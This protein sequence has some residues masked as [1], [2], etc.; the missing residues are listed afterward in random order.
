MEKY[1]KNR[2]MYLD[3]LRF[4]CILIVFIHHV[5]MDV[6]VIHNM[7]DLNDFYIMLFDRKNFNIGMCAIVLY[8]L[9]SGAAMMMVSKRYISNDKFDIVSFYKDRLIR[10]LI[11]FYIVYVMYFIVRFLTVKIFPSAVSGS[12]FSSHPRIYAIFYT[13]C[14]VDEYMNANG[15]ATFSLGI[16]EWFLGCIIFCY[17]VF[18]FLYKIYTK[19]P[20]LTFIFFTLYFLVI[21]I[22]LPAWPTQPYTN[23]F[24]HI[25]NF[26]LG[27]VLIN[28]KI[29]EFQDNNKLII[30]PFS[31]IFCIVFI[32]VNQYNIPIYMNI[33]TTLSSVMIYTLFYYLEKYFK[34]NEFF[35]VFIRKFTTISFEI[36][37]VH[38]SVIYEVNRFFCYQHVDKKLPFIIILYVILTYFFAQVVHY[39]SKFIMKIKNY[40]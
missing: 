24:N 34:N 22:F 38:H 15:I 18:P 7:H 21:Q 27:M 23:F 30:I 40:V 33:K 28:P 25:Y 8:F 5:L 9:I 39:I 29:K 10:I 32:C 36:F 17:M 26:F 31:I 14:G 13:L 3:V 1:N 12:L 16:G 20:I 4:F 6:S 2:I 19:K 11:P 37:L 35:V